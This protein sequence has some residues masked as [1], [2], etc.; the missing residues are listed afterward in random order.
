MNEWVPVAYRWKN[1]RWNGKLD[2]GSK[3]TIVWPLYHTMSLYTMWYLNNGFSGIRVVRSFVFCAMFSIC[4]FGVSFCPLLLVIVLSVLYFWSLCCLFFTFGHCVV[5]PLRLVIV[6]SVLYFWSLCCLSFT[7]G[8][9]VVCPLPL[10][11]VLSVLYF[12]SWCCLSFTFGHCVVCPLLLVIV[13]YVLYFWSL[14]CLSI[15]G[16]YGSPFDI[17]KLALRPSAVCYRLILFKW[18]FL[19]HED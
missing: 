10:V 19:C 3:L 7:F 1:E 11:I 2:F 16:Y 14:C 8:H 6:L 4:F 5:C 12:W 9:C 13:L 15:Y 18:Q 17:F